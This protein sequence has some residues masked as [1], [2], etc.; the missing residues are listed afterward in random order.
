M[1]GWAY[2]GKDQYGREV[3]YAIA[4]V[5]DY[6]GCREVID[7]GLGFLCGDI[8][9]GETGCGRY[10]C[11][12]HRGSLGPKGGCQHKFKGYGITFCQPMLDVM[13]LEVYCA[14]GYE[15]SVKWEADEKDDEW[16]YS[17]SSFTP[18]YEN[19]CW[20]PD[21]D[22]LH[23][24]GT[25]IAEYYLKHHTKPERILVSYHQYVY[26]ELMCAFAGNPLVDFAEGKK[27]TFHGIPLE[28]QSAYT[29]DISPPAF[30][31]NDPA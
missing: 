20:F 25:Q 3:G 4:A 23:W 8:H 18:K 17:N 28:I 13:S 30:W 15:H 12:D 26:L 31:E 22:L 24:L 27:N 16:L 6:P 9:N 1:G 11:F 19:V 7:R 14:C 29:L 10:F 21:L 2:C 5:C